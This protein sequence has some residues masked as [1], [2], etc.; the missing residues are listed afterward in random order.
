MSIHKLFFK[1]NGNEDTATME[2]LQKKYGTTEADRSGAC[3]NSVPAKWI[4]G[5][6]GYIKHPVP[7]FGYWVS[8]EAGWYDYKNGETVSGKSMKTGQSYYMDCALKL[9]RTLYTGDCTYPVYTLALQLMSYEADLLWKQSGLKNNGGYMD[10]LLYID[11]QGKNRLA[12]LS[13]QINETQTKFL[14]ALENMLNGKNRNALPQLYTS[15]GRILSGHYL[16][17]VLNE[18]CSLSDYIENGILRAEKMGK[19]AYR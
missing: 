18:S 4:N 1:D 5:V 6:H 2:T 19:M 15:D 14:T 3:K 13:P 17:I 10:V 9:R 11:A 12:P 7:Y 16:K 8:D